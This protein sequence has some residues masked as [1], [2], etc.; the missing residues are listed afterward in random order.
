[1]ISTDI[2]DC[3]VMDITPQGNGA[4]LLFIKK[5][6]DDAAVPSGYIG[7]RGETADMRND[8]SGYLSATPSLISTWNLI[9]Y[10]DGFLIQQASNQ[11]LETGTTNTTNSVG[12]FML[13]G[14]DG[15]AGMYDSQRS[16]LLLHGGQ[17][18]TYQY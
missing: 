8:L 13:A 7:T 3:A 2:N 12:W 4:H 9:E 18:N 14:I 17:N 6:V 5:R 10:D 1:M 15:T 11:M 16:D